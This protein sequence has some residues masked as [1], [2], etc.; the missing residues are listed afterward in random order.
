[1]VGYVC[2]WDAEE[3]GIPLT[4]IRRAEVRGYFSSLTE[5]QLSKWNH[6]GRNGGYWESQMSSSHCVASECLAQDTELQ[7]SLS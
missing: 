1:M 6:L 5:V 3:V 2:V 7:V 4:L